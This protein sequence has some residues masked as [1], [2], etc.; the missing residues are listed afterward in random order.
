MLEKKVGDKVKKGDVICR[1]Y[2]E[3]EAKMH[4]AITNIEKA[5]VISSEPIEVKSK[6]IEVID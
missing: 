3:S 6:I 1:I 4:H 2:G 5:V